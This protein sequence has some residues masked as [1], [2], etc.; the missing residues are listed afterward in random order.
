MVD[1]EGQEAFDRRVLEALQLAE[2]ESAHEGW[3]V[4][5]NERLVVEEDPAA[6]DAF[7][8]QQLMA[9]HSWWSRRR[10][11]GADRS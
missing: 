9:V 2:P 10:L 6:E 7:W 1:D 11:S 5:S 8:G 4:D 3:S